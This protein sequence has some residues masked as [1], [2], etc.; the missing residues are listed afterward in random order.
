ML[1]VFVLGGRSHNSIVI[2]QESKPYRKRDS[3]YNF[4]IEF[5]ISHPFRHKMYIL[6]HAPVTCFSSIFQYFN[7]IFFLTLSHR[8]VDER[9]IRCNFARLTTDQ[10]YFWCWVHT[11]EKHKECWCL[12]IHFYF[13]G[14]NVKWLCLYVLNTHV[15]SNKLSEGIC[16]SIRSHCSKQMASME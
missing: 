15:V 13:C 3:K 9:A 5:K 4:K 16:E 11:R 1:N 7:G 2:Q 10:L 12:W 6:E 8:D 14:N